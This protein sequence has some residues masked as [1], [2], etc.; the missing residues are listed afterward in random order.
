M[1]HPGGVP[2]RGNYLAQYRL[3]RQCG[4]H[5]PHQQE[6]HWPTLL[7]GWGEQVRTDDENCWFVLIWLK[8]PISILSSLFSSPFFLSF[9]FLSVPLLQL[10]PRHRWNIISQ[11][12]AAAPREQIFCPHSSHGACICHSTLCWESQISSQGKDDEQTRVF[13]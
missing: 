9:C 3:H 7:A 4:L 10:S 1:P 5:P 11:I 2:S 13:S 8:L 12:Q 6:A